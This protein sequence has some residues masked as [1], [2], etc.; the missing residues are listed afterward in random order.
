[1]EFLSQGLAVVGVLEP[2]TV[3][4]MAKLTSA[5]D[6]SKY[7]EV[8]FVFS[9]GDMASETI[10]CGVYE[11]DGSAGTYT[12][13]SGKQATQLAAHASNNDNKQIVIS[14]KAEEL[15]SGKR[16]LKGR[17]ITGGATGGVACCIAIGRGKFQ[18]TSDDKPS[19][20][21]EVVK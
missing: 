8:L 19:S 21:V 5:I 17:M 2:Q 15:G 3:A 9:L 7:S 6:M 11:S 14:V 12:A 10:D 13:L 16:Y 20:V 18:P 4:N 1:M